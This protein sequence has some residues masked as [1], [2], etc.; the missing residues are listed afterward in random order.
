MIIPAIK[1]KLGST[2]YYAANLS[3]KEI[4]QIV[5][6][7]C[8]D[9]GLKCIQGKDVLKDSIFPNALLLAVAEGEPIW[10]EIEVDYKGSK[11]QNWGFFQLEGN[12]SIFA[13]EGETRVNEIKAALK[14]HR[15]LKDESMAVVFVE[16]QK[17]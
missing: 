14:E 16:Y 13:I 2:I 4:A 5:N 7:C 11:Y 9:Y 3:F 12:E 1:G 15:E 17:G 8:D 6:R 10:N